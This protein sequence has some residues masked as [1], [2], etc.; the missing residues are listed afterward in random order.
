MIQKQ[1]KLLSLLLL[2]TSLST[3]L[4][5]QD[6][7]SL[8]TEWGHP[9]LQ[10][11]WNFSS[12]IP[13][14][15]PE[16]FGTR[17][18]LTDQE[19]ADIKARLE[20][21]AEEGSVVEADADVANRSA[22]DTDERFVY[23]Y[24]HFW[25]EMA[26]IADTVRTSQIIYPENGRMPAL[27]EGAPV[28]VSGFLED[29]PGERPVRTGSGGIGKDGPE[30]RGLPER[31][32]I[33]MNALPPYRPSRYNNNLQIIQNRDHVVIVSEM[34]H[35][36]RMIPLYEKPN[37]PEHIEQWTGDSRGYWDGDTL[38]VET[39]NFSFY[40]ASLRSYGTGKEKFLTE[41]FT[42]SDYD[43]LD[44][45]WTLEDPA[46]F[47]DKITAVLPMAKVAGQLYEYACQ[48]G[49]YGLMNILRGAREEERRAAMQR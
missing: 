23:G 16:Q 1:A 22:P 4:V 45:E 34:I 30:D 5:A 38:V 41:R 7:D 3:L 32:I 47:T 11:V 28:G 25:Y 37:L 26:S 49:N 44:Y 48:E 13:F 19:I 35:N 36:A 17:E 6:N 18:F 20:A 9:D 2:G 39:R 10:G 40:T 8:R 27:V 31:C 21:E 29:A 24:D 14:E 43:T 15:R 42:R 46:T 12:E 33:G